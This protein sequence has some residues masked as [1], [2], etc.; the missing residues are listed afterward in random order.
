MNLTVD[1]VNDLLPSLDTGYQL[2]VTNTTQVTAPVFNHR[3]CV[4]G[5]PLLTLLA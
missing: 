4:I 2:S 5:A 1:L 3:A